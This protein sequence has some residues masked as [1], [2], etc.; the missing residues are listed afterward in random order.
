M[1]KLFF[2]FAILLLLLSGC[3][4]IMPIDLPQ[5]T[6]DTIEPTVEETEEPDETPVVELPSNSL[7]S[8]DPNTLENVSVTDGF[9]FS[10]F[11]IKNISLIRNKYFY[12]DFKEISYNP[13]KNQMCVIFDF[14][15]MDYLRANYYMMGR[16][17]GA[18]LTTQQLSYVVASDKGEHGGCFTF[19]D[20]ETTYEILIG[21]IDSDDFTYNGYMEASAVI[22]FTD[23][24]YAERKKVG[25][26]T[27]T[28]DEAI[29][30]T[31][32][33]IPSISLDISIEDS[34]QIVDGVTIKLFEDESG[35]LVET[36]HLESNLINW[37]DGKIIIDNY[38]IDELAPYFRYR[39]RVYIDGFNGIEEFSDVSVQYQ[40]FTSQDILYNN[41]YRRHGFFAQVTSVQINETTVDIN[42]LAR[43][44]PE[45]VSSVDHLPF[46]F[47]LNIY[48]ENDILKKS[49]PIDVNSIS[50]TIPIEYAQ[51]GYRIEIVTDRADITLCTFAIDEPA[52]VIE[53]GY[54][55]NGYLYGTVISG[56]DSINYIL[57]EVYSGPNGDRLDE[58]E[59]SSYFPVNRFNIHFTEYRDYE[60]LDR[61]L[62]F[63]QISYETSTGTKFYPRY[64]W[65]ENR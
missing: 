18:F 65:I 25:V 19:M 58:S 52:P 23:T 31:Y 53:L 63:Y 3:Q 43:N 45:I 15:D 33:S 13:I 11:A 2:I 56:L 39:V 48:D 57:F 59:V 24:N 36:Y 40:T 22:E 42:Y 5:N 10:L 32:N 21:K 61:V 64:L 29:E 37:V 44:N 55:Q 12:V 16:E 6:Q 20:K 46:D 34:A 7:I 49:E 41:G 50:I 9:E 4:D 62:I 1:K 38:V 14:D 30:Y 60:D 26:A 8:V 27:L 28:F 35:V 51:I 17:K 47:I 54:L